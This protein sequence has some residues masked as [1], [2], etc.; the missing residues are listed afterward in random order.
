MPGPFRIFPSALPLPLSFGLCS[1]GE[2]CRQL[3]CPLFTH[4]ETESPAV[5]RILQV[6]ANTSRVRGVRGITPPFGGRGAGRAGWRG[7]PGVDL[8]GIARRADRAKRL[9]GDQLALTELLP[10][11]GPPSNAVSMVISTI[12]KVRVMTPISQR[13]KLMLKEVKCLA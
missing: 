5:G 2:R 8:Q 1:S 10:I 13:R 7:C 6:D 3:P 9:E 12:L 11:A 4:E